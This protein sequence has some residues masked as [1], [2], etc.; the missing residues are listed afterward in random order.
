MTGY[1]VN[2]PSG[3]PDAAIRRGP[4]ILASDTRLIPFRHGVEVPPMYRY[5]F[6]KN[7]DGSIDLTLVDNPPVKEI[8]MTFQVPVTD[9]S[10]KQHEL[11]MCD[12]ASAGNSWKAGNL[13]R[14]WLPQP[15]DFRHLYINNLD[16]RINVTDNGP[17]PEIPEIYKKQNNEE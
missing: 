13:F 2:A 5:S 7:R 10:G 15:F 4:V 8:W 16:W 9:E 14:V 3:V 17:R 11:P 1:V 12:Y 6:R